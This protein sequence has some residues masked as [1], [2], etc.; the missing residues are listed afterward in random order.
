VKLRGKGRGNMQ[1]GSVDHRKGNSRFG[2]QH[3]GSSQN[4]AEEDG[5]SLSNPSKVQSSGSVRPQLKGTGDRSQKLPGL[6]DLANG[7]LQDMLGTPL[8]PQGP[9]A[10]RQG[11]GTEMDDVETHASGMGEEENTLHN[12]PLQGGERKN[13]ALMKGRQERP[14]VAISLANGASATQS[15]AES[16][17]SWEDVQTQWDQLNVLPEKQ[18]RQPSIRPVRPSAPGNPPIIASAETEETATPE[19]ESQGG[20]LRPQSPVKPPLTFPSTAP[21][22]RPSSLPQPMLVE[23][24][25]D[26]LTEQ[27]QRDFK[28]Y[29]GA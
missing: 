1:A 9:P 18:K 16:A 11:E 3:I 2:D 26:A 20:K 27:L 15:P 10:K 17:P 21:Q 6:E 8:Q 12:H 23:D 24:M 25:L 5:T 29:Y 13:K 4:G 19:M 14:E 22:N 7:L 28:R